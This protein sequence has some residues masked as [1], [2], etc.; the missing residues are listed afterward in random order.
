MMAFRSAFRR[1]SMEH[2]P[3]S[4]VR[5]S[6]RTKRQK[7]SMQRHSSRGSSSLFLKVKRPSSTIILD[8]CGA[9]GRAC[10]RPTASLAHLRFRLLESRSGSHANSGQAIAWLLIKFISWRLRGC[11][12]SPHQFSTIL[13]EQENFLSFKARPTGLP[14][15]L[16][17]CSVN[18]ICPWLCGRSVFPSDYHH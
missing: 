17:R 10:S 3:A 15:L 1:R 7:R 18:C 2:I 14:T 9:S 8:N 6:L 11:R 12:V 4:F 5:V 13:C 16:F